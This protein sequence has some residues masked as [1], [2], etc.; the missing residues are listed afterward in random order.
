MFAIIRCLLGVHATGTR[1]APNRAV[2]HQVGFQRSDHGGE[3][4]PVTGAPFEGFQQKHDCRALLLKRELGEGARQKIHQLLC[5]HAAPK[6]ILYG[7]H[8]QRSAY[9]P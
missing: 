2:L 7:L 8:P 3:R 1:P 5:V 9:P 4:G 6:V